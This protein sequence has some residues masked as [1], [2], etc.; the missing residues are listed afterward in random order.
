MHKIACNVGYQVENNMALKDKLGEDLK[1]AMRAG[2]RAKRTVLRY[3]LSEIHNQEIASQKTLDEGGVIQVLTKQAQQRRDSIEAFEKGG[4]DDLVQKETSELE[5]IVEYLP[6]Q[7]T[8]D[9]VMGIIDEAI[10]EVEPTGPQDMGKVM[11]AIMPHV[12]GRSDGK[13]VSSI[14]SEKL[15]N[16]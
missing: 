8:R 15:R 14:V 10:S 5:L 11:S 2:D 3:L 9:E 6:R 16:L 12:R 1:D 7:L 13:E 4:R